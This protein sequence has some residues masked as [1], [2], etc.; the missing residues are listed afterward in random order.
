MKRSSLGQQ[1]NETPCGALRLAFGIGLTL[2]AL[3]VHC[4][5]LLPTP[6]PPAMA[7]LPPLVPSAAFLPC[8]T[9]PASTP[10]T[11]A[12]SGVTLTGAKKVSP[13]A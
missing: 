12:G 5:L 4:V 7:F 3:E 6:P 1:D 10:R 8:G 11:G 9:L 13:K 2:A